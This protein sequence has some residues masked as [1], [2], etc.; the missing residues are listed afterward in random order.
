MDSENRVKNIRDFALQQAKKNKTI[1]T[2]QEDTEVVTKDLP[3]VFKPKNFLSIARS[4]GTNTVTDLISKYAIQDDDYQD[5]KMT[6]DTSKKV[7][8]HLGRMVTGVGASIPIICR[9]DNCSYKETCVTGDTLVLTTK[10][11][12]E[13]KVIAEKDKVYSFN[14]DTLRLEIDTIVNKT[15]KGI[16]DIWE[17][18]TE[19]G[20]KIR[21]TEDHKVLSQ[22]PNGDLCWD[23]LDCSLTLNSKILVT[24]GDDSL[25]DESIG[26]CFIDTI[27]SVNK[28]N[29]EEVF[30]IEI[31]NNSNFI[32]N[33]I[34][35]HN[36]PLFKDNAHM[37]G[38]KCPIE[39]GLIEA[40]A[41]DFI[42]DLEIDPNSIIEIHALSRILEITV[43]EYRLTTY[44]S[45]HDQDLTIE[46]ITSVTPEGEP[47]LNK[48]PSIAFEQRERLSREKIKHLETL[49]A[50]RER[51]QKLQQAIKEEQKI[52]NSFQEISKDVR[53]IARE[54]KMKSVV[55]DGK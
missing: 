36:C 5:L 21:L 12:K 53:A 1:P 11:L 31:K 20:N 18:E 16:K 43:L 35:V 24:D 6:E 23:S 48:A 41:E 52:D 49:N 51:K 46:T 54:L 7:K 2:V 32:A 30:D 55:G 19:L 29:K 10:G 44:L 34:V 3:E 17:I 33:N 38:E 39:V 47:I 22:K 8:K 27:I 13:I 9:G 42:R 50:T 25:I 40:W 45:I 14:P 28:T 15:I 26:D 37:L 4:T